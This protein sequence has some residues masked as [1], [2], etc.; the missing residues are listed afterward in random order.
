M[1]A[2]R[3]HQYGGPEVLLTEDAPEPIAGDGEILIQVKASGVNPADAGLRAGHFRSLID[4]P[5][6]IILGFDLAGIVVSTGAGVTDFAPGDE[7]Y[8]MSGWRCGAHA[9][10]IALPAAE[11]AL[12]PASLDFIEAAAL[13]LGILT[14]YQAIFDLAGLSAGQT[15]LVH[16]ASGG[17]GSIAVQLAKAKGAR[18]IGTASG[19][20]EE[21]VRGLGVDQFVDY[22]T[23]KFEEVVSDVDV[24]FDT[25][26]GDTQ[27]RSYKVMKP[28]GF[29]VAATQPPSPETLAANGVR[30]GMVGAVPNGAQLREVAGLVEASQVKAHV[31]VVLP[32]AEIQ[33][34]HRQI[35]THHTR[36]KIVLKVGE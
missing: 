20:N 30:G 10:Y 13:P 7:V 4:P 36:G 1:Q 5:L 33:E 6:P 32:L 23:T 16:A 24:V 12:K 26:G 35:E 31:E 18:V 19:R 27:E 22:T 17:V 2:V 14:S 11:V 29:L 34:A 28:G 25:M 15:L 3:I 21:F 8:A 9:E